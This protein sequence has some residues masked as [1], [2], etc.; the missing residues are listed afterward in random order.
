MLVSIRQ[1]F[2]QQESLM[3]IV[4]L[5]LLDECDIWIQEPSQITFD[6]RPEVIWKLTDRKLRST[7]RRR[8]RCMSVAEFKACGDQLIEDSPKLSRYSPHF[9]A[10]ILQRIG[11]IIA[12]HVGIPWIRIC[13][14]SVNLEV[15]TA[16]D[17]I[18][19]IQQVFTSVF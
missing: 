6:A 16:L 3:S 11:K 8:G 9:R 2:E 18:L 10:Y 13:G 15:P 7:F 5:Q 14:D 1:C 17:H 4:R 12:D 19:Q